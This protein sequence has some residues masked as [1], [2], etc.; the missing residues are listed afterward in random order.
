MKVEVKTSQQDNFIGFI[1]H[2]RRRPGDVFNLPDAP[3]RALFKG[4]VALVD[5]NEEAK[6]A[7]EQIKDKDGKIPQQFSFR[8]MSPVGAS[9]PDKLSTSQETLTAKQE[10]IKSER[11][12]AKQAAAGAG[13]VSGAGDVL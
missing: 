5:S 1:G 11:A 4:E 3:R 13:G 10:Q 8:W 2:A 9:T 12:A 6:V 7:Y